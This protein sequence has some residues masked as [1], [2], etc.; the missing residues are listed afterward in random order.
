MIIL[1]NPENSL[2][3]SPAQACISAPCTPL[4]ELLAK[5][6]CFSQCQYLLSPQ[7]WILPFHSL[8]IINNSP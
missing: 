5:A 4:Y 6:L 3:I 1:F 2:I 8:R 7:L